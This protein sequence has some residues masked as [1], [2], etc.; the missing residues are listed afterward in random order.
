LG[1]EQ[2]AEVTVTRQVTLS[3]EKTWTRLLAISD[4]TDKFPLFHWRRY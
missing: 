3:P 2:Y 4:S 1:F